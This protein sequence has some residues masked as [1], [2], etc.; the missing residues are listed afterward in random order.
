M[1]YSYLLLSH[2]SEN[3]RFVCQSLLLYFTGDSKDVHISTEESEEEKKKRADTLWADFMKDTGFRSRTTKQ[4][5]EINSLKSK[6]SNISERQSGNT[7]QK[8][9]EK[10]TIKKVFEF[11]G[12]EVIVEKEVPADAPEAR[13]LQKPSNSDTAKGVKGACRASGGLKSVLNQLGKKTKISTLEKS[14]IDWERYK[15]EEKIEDE[16]AAHNKGKDG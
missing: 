1:N 15:R 2:Y 13:L 6:C 10:V 4:S 7:N 12:E 9:Q 5:N 16:L 8:V 3:Q 14:K 11:A